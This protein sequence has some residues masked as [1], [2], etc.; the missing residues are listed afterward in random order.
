[1]LTLI[2]NPCLAGAGCASRSGCAIASASPGARSRCVCEGVCGFE[3]GRRV[4]EHPK[5]VTRGTAPF[6]V[7][8]SA[9]ANVALA[10]VQHHDVLYSINAETRQS[11]FLVDITYDRFGSAHTEGV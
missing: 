4:P 1:M 3:I 6:R 11:P 9:N 7:P 2:V 10:L 8:L 5:S